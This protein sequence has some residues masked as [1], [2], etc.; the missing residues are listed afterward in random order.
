[1]ANEKDKMYYRFTSD[2]EPSEEQ[3]LLLMQE[4]KEEVREENAKL[5][6]IIAENILREYQNAKKMFPNL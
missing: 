6:S 2:E 1:M 5:K 3:L 4:V